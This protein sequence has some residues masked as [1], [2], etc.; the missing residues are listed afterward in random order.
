MDKKQIYEIINKSGVIYLAT[1]ANGEPRVRAMMLYRADENGIVFHTGPFK[2]V[3]K[4]IQENPT[5]QMCFYDEGSGVQ[6]RVRGRLEESND[7]KLKEEIAHHPSR[8]FMQSWKQGKT[9]EE[10]YKM[11]SV[12]TLKGGLA[13]LWTFMTNFEPKEDIAL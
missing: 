9:D 1:T 6:V 11:F 3:Y 7:Q 10:F 8:T 12:F 5:V 2:E 4:Q 13:N